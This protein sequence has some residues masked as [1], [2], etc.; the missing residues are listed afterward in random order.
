MIFL[1]D[2]LGKTDD[3]EHKF[4]YGDAVRV[5]WSNFDYMYV[6]PDEHRI[7]LFDPKYHCVIFVSSTEKLTYQGCKIVLTDEDDLRKIWKDK[8]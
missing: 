6:G 3:T 5:S 4:E 1:D 8:K 2:I 7:R